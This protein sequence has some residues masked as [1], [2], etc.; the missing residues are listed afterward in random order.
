MAEQCTAQPMEHFLFT[1]LIHYFNCGPTNGEQCMSADTN[2]M[3]VSELK[4]L[5]DQLIANGHGDDAV[6]IPYTPVQASMGSRAAVFVTNASVG[7]DWDNGRVFLQPSQ[8]IGLPMAAIL[9]HTKQTERKMGKILMLTRYLGRDTNIPLE[10]QIET[11]KTTTN[12][13]LLDRP[14]ASQTPVVEK[15]TTDA[16]QTKTQKLK[17]AKPK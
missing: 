12:G 6:A 13:I 17:Q 15:Q 10:E 14:V 2:K 9:E 4:N 3:T 7:F 5:L 16:S 8:E 11:F 1:G